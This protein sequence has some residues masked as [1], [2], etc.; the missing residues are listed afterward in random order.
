LKAKRV[1]KSR[2]TYAAIPA[3]RF[4]RLSIL[5][6]VIAGTLVRLSMTPA[7]PKAAVLKRR[8]PFAPPIRFTA[9]PGL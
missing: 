7:M 5:G 4:Q 6:D 3:V 1:I 2:I 9:S 8:S